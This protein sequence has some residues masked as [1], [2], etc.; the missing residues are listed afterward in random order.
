MLT[1]P[2]DRLAYIIEKAREFDAETSEERDASNPADDGERQVLLST[3][4]NPSEEELR[5]AL[6][7]LNQDQ[8]VE[9][10][11]MVLIGR[12]DFD[13]ED[14]KAAFEAARSAVTRD[15]VDYLVGTPMLSD[16]LEEAASELGISFDE[17][18]R[19]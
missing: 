8:R 19:L 14:W 10:M 6:Q 18:R 3:P 7:S 4:D 1:I 12:G 5:G 15:E 9:L 13:A 17:F 11:A 2:R 16:Y